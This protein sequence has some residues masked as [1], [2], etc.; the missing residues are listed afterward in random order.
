MTNVPFDQNRLDSLMQ[1]AGIDIILATSKHNVQYLTGGHRFFWFDYMDAVGVS[2][3]L[4]VVGYSREDPD[5]TFYVGNALENNQLENDP[6]WIPTMDLGTWGVSDAIDKSLEFIND[7]FDGTVSVGVE[8][9]FLPASA[10]EQLQQFENLQLTDAEFVLERLRACKGSMEQKLVEKSSKKTVDSILATFKQIEPGMTK[11]QIVELL[12]LEE[13]KRGLTFEYCLINLGSS[14]NRGASEQVVREGDIVCLDSGGNYNG[15]IG[16]LARMGIVG[17]PNSDHEYALNEV[18]AVQEAARSTVAAGVFGRQLFDQGEKRLSSSPLADD[19][20]FVAHGMGLV[21]HEAP[22]MT[23]TGP[24]PYPNEDGERPLE[25]GMVLSIE[26]TLFHRKFGFIK[27]EDT[28]I[29]T[30]TGYNAVGDHGRDWNICGV[31]K[32]VAA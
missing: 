32:E 2:R 29:V 19:M 7:R 4:P 25:P 18:R 6:V 15:Y 10:W 31:R 27:L 20:T 8:P 30:E 3:Y 24:V 9:N 23:S 17:E 12:R 16:D 1:E 21:S 11:R 28:L 22:R 5:A 14:F 13:V 26:T